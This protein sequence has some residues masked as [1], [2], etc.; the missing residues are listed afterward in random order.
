[1]SAAHAGDLAEICNHAYSG[2]L[3]KVQGLVDRYGLGVLKHQDAEG[4]TPLYCAVRGDQ[5]RVVTYLLN[6]ANVREFI[7]V[8]QSSMGST[9]L[10]C[11]AYYGSADLVRA[12]CAAGASMHIQNHHGDTAA[13]DTNHAHIAT[14]MQAFDKKDVVQAS[15]GKMLLSA[16][17]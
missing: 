4:R 17:L 7:D 2:E 1:M 15:V 3:S 8:R 6:Q 10:H 16:V 11:A 12:L 14:V 9:A 13:S 5:A